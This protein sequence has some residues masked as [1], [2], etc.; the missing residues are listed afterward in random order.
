MEAVG[1]PSVSNQKNIP[2]QI[3]PDIWPSN[4]P[5]SYTLDYNASGAREQEANK[6]L[7]N[8][9]EELKSRITSA[10]PNLNKEIVR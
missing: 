6:I 1:R 7:Y 5:D 3:I 2:G 8:T 9:K 10:F 4:Y